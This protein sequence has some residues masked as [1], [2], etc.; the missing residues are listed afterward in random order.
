MQEIHDPKIITCLIPH[1]K[2]LEILEQLAK[3][4]GIVMANKSNA[5]GTSYTTD[6]SWVEMEILEVIVQ[7]QQADEIFAYLFEVAEIGTSQGG[8][9]FQHALS[10]A[11][12]YHVE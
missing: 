8:L 1:H 12:D 9:I 5:R 3:E 7:A 4:K 2:S 10:R 6:F 11:S